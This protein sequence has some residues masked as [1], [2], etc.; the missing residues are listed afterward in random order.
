MMF[1]KRSVQPTQVSRHTASRSFVCEFEKAR[2]LVQYLNQLYK[3]RKWYAFNRHRLNSRALYVLGN[4]STTI[5]NSRTRN[6]L[7]HYRM[8]MEEETKRFQMSLVFQIFKCSRHLGNAVL[9]VHGLRK[10]QSLYVSHSVLMD[11]S[12]T[13]PILIILHG[14]GRRQSAPLRTFFQSMLR[15]SIEHRDAH[16]REIKLDALNRMWNEINILPSE[17]VTCGCVYLN[18][19]FRCQTFFEAM[20][21]S[22]TKVF[23]CTAIKPRCYCQ[24]VRRMIAGGFNRQIL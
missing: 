1:P 6:G 15:I 3:N 23:F 4:L 12:C 24:Q 14:G 5:Q 22:E 9:D 16:T 2:S 8:E 18:L 19:V 10:P 13:I 11:G 21:G 7:Y 20:H 17:R